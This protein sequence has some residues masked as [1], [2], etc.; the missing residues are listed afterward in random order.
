VDPATPPDGTATFTGVCGGAED[1]R[2]FELA[3]AGTVALLER[4]TGMPDRAFT[5]ELAGS[6]FVGPE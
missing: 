6:V 4:C 3:L 2:G 5:A 1:E